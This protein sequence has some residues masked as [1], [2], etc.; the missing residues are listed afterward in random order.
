MRLIDIVMQSPKTQSCTVGR[1]TRDMPAAGVLASALDG[2]ATRYVLDRAASA[3]VSRLVSIPGGPIAYPD[4]LTRLPARP[5]WLECWP[6]ADPYPVT[7]K[8][9]LCRYGFYVEPFAD[10]RGGMVECVVETTNGEACLLAA[11]VEFDLT[12]RTLSPIGERCHRMRHAENPEVDRLLAM[13][14]LIV[15]EDW[16][17]LARNVPAKYSEFVAWQAQRAW[18]SVPLLLGFS[19]LLNTRMAFIER[20]SSLDRL[21]SGRTYK[22]RPA[23]L[24]H[25]E[26]GLNL[27][28]G[29]TTHPGG[30]GVA[31]ARQTPRFHFVRGHDVTRGGR[32]FWRTSHF[33][34]DGSIEPTRT[35]RVTAR[36]GCTVT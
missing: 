13:S 11:H 34:G 33:R 12:E 3:Q 14:R 20:P 16:M 21:N 17:R 23:L 6:D 7:G 28:P 27:T 8:Q 4:E 26:L 29:E 35:F 19:A 30:Q 18:N 31:A 25:I 5:F 32:T 2:C 22:G 10:G 1:V 24:E 36:G 9:T 15:G